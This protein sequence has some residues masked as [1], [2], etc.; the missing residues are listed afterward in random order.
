MLIEVV[1]YY[2]RLRGIKKGAGINNK[3]NKGDYF[4]LLIKFLL[5]SLRLLFR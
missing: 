2:T 3:T 4:I 5:L 1:I